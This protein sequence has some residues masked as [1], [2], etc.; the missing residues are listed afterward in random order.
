MEVRSSSPGTFQLL[1]LQYTPATVRA[2]IRLNFVGVAVEQD[3]L[4]AAKMPLR[5]VCLLRRLSKLFSDNL[6]VARR[7]L[8][9]QGVHPV[10]RLW[11]KRSRHHSDGHLDA[12]K[13]FHSL[14]KCPVD[15]FWGHFGRQGTQRVDTRGNSL[16]MSRLKGVDLL[17]GEW[18][19]QVVDCH[20]AALGRA[21]RCVECVLRVK[22]AQI[23]RHVVEL[24]GHLDWEMANGV[25]WFWLK[26]LMVTL[27]KSRN[28]FQLIV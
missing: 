17:L 15:V 2:T 25:E 5:C 27:V 26:L 19:G 18:G 12:W 6:H 24:I 7:K 22:S 1:P 11:R 14:L 20:P 3:S 28:M 13:R 10:C 21:I 9:I 8:D 4:R 23:C 16:D